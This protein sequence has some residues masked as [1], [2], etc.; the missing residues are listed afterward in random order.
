LDNLRTK[1]QSVIQRIDKEGLP[2]IKTHRTYKEETMSISRPI[3][4]IKMIDSIKLNIETIEKEQS[5]SPKKKEE[6]HA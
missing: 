2:Q 5:K 6:I 1:N 3:N 4:L